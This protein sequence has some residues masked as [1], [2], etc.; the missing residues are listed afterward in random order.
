[1]TQ[2][3][4]ATGVFVGML[5]TGVWYSLVTCVGL[6]LVSGVLSPA[7]PDIVKAALSM[8]LLLS[9]M[10]FVGWDPVTNFFFKY[11]KQDEV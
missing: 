5:I 8:I 7:T 10:L 4:T 6:S 1:M 2:H 11:P 3:I 9:G